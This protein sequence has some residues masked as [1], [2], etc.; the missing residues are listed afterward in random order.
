M[1]KFYSLFSGFLVASLFMVGVGFAPL[2]G[3]D[4]A[5]DN[6]VY[7][8]GEAEVEVLDMTAIVP[9]KERANTD[10]NPMNNSFDDPEVQYD[11][12][13]EN[14]FWDADFG[15]VHC[16]KL[17]FRGCAPCTFTCPDDPVED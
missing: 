16:D 3:P 17:G 7:L 5:T 13:W 9:N 1:Q 8:D 12:D 4:M 6:A 10:C 15:C 14:C 11:Y 2:D